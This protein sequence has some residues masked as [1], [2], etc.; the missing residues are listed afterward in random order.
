[1]TVTTAAQAD[2]LGRLL[3]V[4]QMLDALPDEQQ[5]REFTRRALAQIPGVKD[6]LVCIRGQMTPPDARYQAICAQ[7]AQALDDPDAID[8]AA[9]GSE[10]GTHCLPMRTVSQ[11][12]G[13][14]IVIVSD[15]VLLHPYLGFL[16]NIANTIGMVLNTRLHHER[17]TE[18]NEQR[19]K[20]LNRTYR[21][22]SRCTHHLIRARD[23]K[24][25]A[26][27]LCATMVE[28]GGYR[29]A[30]VGYALRD[31]AK[32]ILP[33]AHAGQ[34]SG[35]L[36]DLILTWADTERGSGPGARCI[37]DG[38]PKVT[39]D[40]PHDPAFAFWREEA[41]KRGYVSSI[42]MPLKNSE[43]TFGFLGMYSAS[44]NAFDEEEVALLEEVA[45]DL[46]FGIVTLRER[47][48]RDALTQE[49]AYLATHDPLTRLANRPLLVDRLQQ[50]L[51]HARHRQRPV[52]I[53]CLDLDNFK[54]VNDSFGTAL[55]NEVLQEIARRL[56]GLLRGGSTAARFSSGE[57]VLLLTEQETL[58]DISATLTRVLA[59]VSEPMHVEGQEITVTGSIGCSLFPNDGEEPEILL[60]R[61]KVSMHRAKEMGRDGMSFFTAGSDS[62][63]TERMN[64]E[65]DLRHA[66]RDSELVLYYQPQV[67]L[68][69]RTLVGFE[70]LMR[71]RH[72]QRG[73]ISPAAFIPV[74][75]DSG[76][77]VPMGEWALREGCR[78]AREWQDA[79]V[80]RA[81]MAINLSP[82]QFRDKRIVDTV[83]SILQETGLDP[84]QL[85]LEITEGSIMRDVDQ[86]I[87][88]MSEFKSLGATLSID[89]FGTGYS[90]L[91]YLRRFPVD[92][93]KIDQSFV[94]DVEKAPSA[95]AIVRT[96]IVLGHSLGL[97]VI[98]EGVETVSE[99]RFLRQN[100][101]D[102]M[103]GFL[104][105]RPLPAHELQATFLNPA[106][107]L[108][109]PS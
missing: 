54:R 58:S 43:G 14:L 86:V 83:R 50:A 93:L 73:L 39:R 36:N 13:L 28:E 65:I 48:E 34:E 42:A 16:A 17:Q 10:P 47:A 63:V 45:D 55:G 62:A 26:Q 33:F 107:C 61:A 20:R 51:S 96:I 69:T 95:A 79:G 84:P 71:W 56:R 31:E 74:A 1:M 57:F 23:E 92:K 52:A 94:R 29:M 25:L 101:C 40:I 18:T 102:E 60:R 2:V 81:T 91:N 22:I 77:I 6:V 53:A 85:E 59:A 97:K 7:C 106:A 89:D 82:R 88:I 78:Q 67:H 90:S 5:I 104:I 21:T 19:L 49:R 70:A 72:P 30:W 87:A 41:A 46:A 98:A 99:A 64:L 35:Y 24:T 108:W 27:D 68:G 8:W 100:G 37:R 4:Q 80:A 32:T 11:L 75:E 103:Q 44:T 105:E 15:E 9:L 3:L 38:T 12:F 76:L 109:V 66:V